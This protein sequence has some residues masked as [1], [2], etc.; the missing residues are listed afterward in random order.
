MSKQTKIAIV[1]A[2][3]AWCIYLMFKTPLPFNK[4]RWD[5]RCS[6]IHPLK[7]PHRMADRLVGSDVLIGKSAAEVITLLDEPK[8]SGYFK[9]YDFAY[10]L[11]PQRGFFP[12][13]NEWLVLKLDEN[14]EVFEAAVVSD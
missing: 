8:P 5:K 14:G 12:M 6:G 11:G 3:V 7:L 10:C 13:D 9:S 2:V 4:S 1:I